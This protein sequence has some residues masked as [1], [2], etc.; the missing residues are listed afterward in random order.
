MSAVVDRQTER[1]SGHLEDLYVRH[2]PEATRL[3]FL[4]TS[5][6]ELAQDLAQEAF[7]RV[8]GRFA[9]LRQATVFESSSD[10]RS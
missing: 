3:A 9:H 6:R 7:I 8:A 4:L 2:S 10:E 1:R 5:D